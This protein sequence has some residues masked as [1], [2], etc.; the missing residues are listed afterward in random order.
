MWQQRLN[1]FDLLKT[2]T[3]GSFPP[4]AI[5]TNYIRKQG[6]QNAKY[7]HRDVSYPIQ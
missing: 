5:P 7:C 3:E 4:V 1:H 6:R 2:Q